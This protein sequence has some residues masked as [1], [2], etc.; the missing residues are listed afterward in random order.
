M[1]NQKQFM[2]FTYLLLTYLWRVVSG[3]KP[4]YRGFQSLPPSSSGHP[5]RRQMSIIVARS[6]FKDP[7]VSDQV[8]AP[9]RIP[10]SIALKKSHFVGSV[11]SLH[12]LFL[13][14]W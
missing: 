6:L 13:K 7:I 11:I 9:S 10:S 1:I 3:M 5:A 4:V 8:S 12:T 2:V 14:N